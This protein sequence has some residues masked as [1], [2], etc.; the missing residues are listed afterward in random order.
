MNRKGL[1]HSKLLY[2]AAN[3]INFEDMQRVI[4]KDDVLLINTLDINNQKCLIKNMEH[5]KISKRKLL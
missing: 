4:E 3:K 2:K 1:L 5:L